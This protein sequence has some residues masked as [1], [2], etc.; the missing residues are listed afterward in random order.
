MTRKL[1]SVRR[2][3]AIEPIEDADRIVVA[4][5]D[6]W[7]LITQK[8][9]N[10]QVGDLV[11]YFEIDSFLPVEERFEFLRHS[12]FRSTKN[13]GDGFRI[14]TMKM[15]GQVSQG[16]IL[17]MESFGFYKDREYVDRWI[18]P[19][20]GEFDM[21]FQLEEGD[22]ITEY[23]GV[24]KYEKPVP[25]NLQGR[26][27]GNFPIWI[28]KTDQERL[29]NVYGKYAR[30]YQD[31]E[32]EATLKVDGSSMTAY[33]CKEEGEEVK[34]SVCSHNFDL[35]E[36]EDNLFWQVARK[37]KL[38]EVLAEI[39]QNVALQG[40][41][42]GPGVQKNREQL[43]D[44]EFYLF[45]IWDINKRRYMTPA[46]R[47]YFYKQ[48]LWDKGIVHVPII[49]R[50]IKVF[51]EFPTLEEFLAY[52]DSVRSLKHDIAEGV[53]YKSCEEMGPSFKTISNRF[54]LKEK[55]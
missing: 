20:T 40:E 54:L 34:T 10:F 35:E 44:H 2:I 27:R 11:V 53:V 37:R 26:A 12:S 23:L 49:K 50:K 4:T 16:L 48:Y 43:K 39:G 24:Q 8:S 25:S 33:Y 36:T 41:L 46:E 17:P 3:D 18:S 19:Y 30:K 21:Q 9:N 14:K 38:L 55:D 1:A 6:G 15:R 42:M 32:F 45:D 7:K 51:Q 22:D 5:V 52:A 47:T 28:A 13:L 29:Q 31:M